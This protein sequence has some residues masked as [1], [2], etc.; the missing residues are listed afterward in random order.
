MAFALD[1]AFEESAITLGNLPLSRVLLSDDARYPW[2][3][4]VP[5]RADISEIIDLAPADRAAL[6][7]EIVAASEALKALYGPDKLNVGAL[8]NHVRQLHIHVI[9]R[10][11]SDLAWPGPV[12]GHSPAVPYPPHMAGMAADR[13]IKA[14]TPHG[15]KEIRS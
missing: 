15:L 12:W 5:Q 6:M 3:I 14:L 2:L 8:G 9:A 1:P 10:F 11:V 4:L 7:D 13:I